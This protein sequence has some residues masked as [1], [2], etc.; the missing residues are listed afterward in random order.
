MSL[1]ELF[2]AV[3]DFCHHFEPQWRQ[4]LLATGSRRRQRRG[5]LSTSE[6]L[7][8]LIHFHQTHYRDFKAYYLHYVAVQLRAEFPQLVSYQRFVE[9]IPTIVVPPCAYLTTC[10]GRCIGISFIDSTAL[11][12]CHNRRIS[13]HNVFAGIAQRGK[14]SLGWLYGSKLHVV[15]N[16]RGE[17]ISVQL[18]P[19]NTDDR[20][21]VLSRARR[22]YGKRFGDTGYLSQALGRRLRNEQGLQL[23]THRKRNMN[24]Q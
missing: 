12:V 20:N 17:L 22:L 2:C 11:A 13:Q 16:D 1:L 9:L 15:L 21:P 23:I 19:G 10:F 7:T 6:I 24:Q 14:T 18:T 8:I 5:Q 3:D 4:H